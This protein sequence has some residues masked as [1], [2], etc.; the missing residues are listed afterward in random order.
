M[1]VVIA[2]AGIA[3]AGIHQVW[4]E[5]HFVKVQTVDQIDLV[6]A[7]IHERFGK[8]L[9]IETFA[10]IP[11]DLKPNVQKD[12]KEKFYETWTRSEAYQLGVNGVM[13]LITGDPPHLQ[14][15]VG[16]DTQKKAFTLADRD[17]LVKNLAGA[18]RQKKFDDG[19]LAAAEFVRDRM[20]RNIGGAAGGAGT[21]PASAPT[22]QP[23]GATQP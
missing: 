16:S 17:E 12:G 14:V 20:A 3:S 11:D 10:S 23:A 2:M 4:E 1:V 22:T 6:L 21:R 18:F 8:D 19:L 13:I 7:D 5:A 9:M 15:E